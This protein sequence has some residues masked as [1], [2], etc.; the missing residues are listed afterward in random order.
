LTSSFAGEHL[1]DARTGQ[2][3]TFLDASPDADSSILRVLV[4]LD[5]GG[6]VPRHIHVRQDERVE[7]LAGS[8]AVTSGGKTRMLRAGDAVDVPRRSLHVV[9]NAGVDEARFVL[10]VRPARRMKLAM[11]TLF[12]ITR[13]FGRSPVV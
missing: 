7:V 5:P 3:L 10:E 12:A 4:R 1:H 8:V 6:R 11:R 13:R 9:R 2:H